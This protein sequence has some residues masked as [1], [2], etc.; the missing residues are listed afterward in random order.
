MEITLC[1]DHVL[2]FLVFIGTESGT[3]DNFNQL[4][5][6]HK[7]IINCFLFLKL[8]PL[9]TCPYYPSRKNVVSYFFVEAYNACACLYN[10]KYS[11]KSVFCLDSRLHARL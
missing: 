8:F 4:N 10:Y 2:F 9:Q 11:V 7:V 3:S 6:T 5:P 1:F